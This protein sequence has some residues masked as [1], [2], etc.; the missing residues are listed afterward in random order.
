ML[1]CMQK[2]NYLAHFFLKMLQIANFLFW[3]NW[4]CLATRTYNDGINLKK[5]LMF[6]WKQKIDFIIPVFLEIFQRY[7][8]LVILGTLGKSGYIN[9]NNPFLIKILNC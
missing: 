4:A 3:V 9:P 1:I 6:I 7:C 5:S 2:I 8:K